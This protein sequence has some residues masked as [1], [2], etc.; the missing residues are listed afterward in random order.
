TIIKVSLW[1]QKAWLL[2]S[3]GEAILEADIA[4]GVENKETPEGV[5]QVLERMESKRSNQYGRIVN[6]ET[7]EVVIEKSWEHQGPLPEGTEYEGIEMPYWMRLTWDGIGMHVGEFKKRTRCSFG[8][9]RVYER[10][11]PL[12]FAKTQLGTKIEVVQDSLRNRYSW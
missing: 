2:N 12:I 10:A 11:Q 9:I 8:C 3:E 1:D 4:T 7:R 6:R 5:F